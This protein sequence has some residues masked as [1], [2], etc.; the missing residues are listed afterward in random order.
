MI[1]QI[2]FEIDRILKKLSQK[3]KKAQNVV[4]NLK[5][6]IYLLF[7]CVKHIHVQFKTYLKLR[8]IRFKQILNKNYPDCWENP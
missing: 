2:G 6:R 1:R 4:I 3:T 8:N 5:G 7:Y